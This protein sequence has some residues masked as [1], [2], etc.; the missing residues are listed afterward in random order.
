MGLDPL[1]LACE[2]RLVI[3]L[4]EK[5]AN[6]FLKALKQN[7]YTKDSAIIGKVSDEMPGLVTLKTEIGTEAILPEPTGELLPRIC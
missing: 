2:G 1:Y 4:K 5:I 6:K 7:K 3:I